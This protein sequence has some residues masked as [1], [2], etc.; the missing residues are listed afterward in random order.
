MAPQSSNSTCSVD[1]CNS[2]VY[3]RGFC[4]KHWQR[5][6]KHGDP[7]VQLR[8]SNDEYQAVRVPLVCVCCGGQFYRKPSRV[9]RYGG[10]FCSRACWDKSHPRLPVLERLWSKVN[11]D[12]PVP[13]YRPDLGPC[14]IWTD[15]PAVNGYAKFEWEQ[16]EVYAHRFVYELLV[17]PIPEGLDLDH[18]CRV[19]NCVNPAHLEPVTGRVNTLR[20]YSPSAQHA[21]QT[22]CRHGH[23]FDEANTRIDRHGWRICR[24]CESL[25]SKAQARKHRVARPSNVQ[26]IVDEINAMRRG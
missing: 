13:E 2:P 19:R 10:R 25:R 12:A 14:W 21:R 18:L 1:G 8:P 22:H 20:G 24:A 4:S 26:D 5:W 7:L 15:K 16:G 11:K 23:P 9:I 17:G 3:G 6:H